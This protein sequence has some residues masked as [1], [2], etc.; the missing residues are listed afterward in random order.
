VAELLVQALIGADQVLALFAAVPRAAL[1]LQIVAQLDDY[2]R[3]GHE[4]FPVLT[5][6]GNQ[7]SMPLCGITSQPRCAVGQI[8]GDLA[9]A[10]LVDS[11]H[12]LGGL[13]DLSVHRLSAA[14]LARVEIDPAHRP[15]RMLDGGSKRI[16]VSDGLA[17]FTSCPGQFLFELA[18]VLAL[19]GAGALE[20]IEYLRFALDRRVGTPL[21]ALGDFA[22]LV[23]G[24]KAVVALL[25]L[26]K[27]RL[28]PC[29]DA[30]SGR[31]DHHLPR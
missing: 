16:L 18:A 3:Q 31:F 25:G 20:L 8:I 30:S 17:A 21:Q 14:D 19:P 2:R 5:G 23:M 10:P 4:R 27:D 1:L 22:H 9:T 29:S 24:M 28:N 11:A 6:E 12:R 7:L 26:G 15:A 13:T